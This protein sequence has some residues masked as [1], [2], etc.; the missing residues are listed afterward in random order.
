MKEQEL[1][2]RLYVS[3]K[4]PNQLRDFSAE[5]LG[6]LVLVVLEYIK[7]V[8]KAIEDGK[9][10]GEPA[11]HL[12]PDV[13]YIS[14]DTTEKELAEL[15]IM[16]NEKYTKDIEKLLK[17]VESKVESKLKTLRNGKDAEI[18][19]KQL[20]EIAEMAFGMIELP[21]FTTFI[22]QE[23]EAVRNALE[24][25]QG[26]EK[27]DMN[28]IRGLTEELDELQKNLE[29]S[30]KST[31]NSGKAV[32]K[33][34]IAFLTDV[35][36]NGIVEDDILRYNGDK[37][38]PYALSNK[39]DLINGKIP[40]SQLPSIA[41]TETFVVTSQAEMLA[42]DAQDGD[43]AVRTDTNETYV[44]QGDDP[45]VLGNWVELLTSQTLATISQFSDTTA[46]SLYT[47]TEDVPVEFRRAN[48]STLAYFDETNK[49]F[50]V[51]TI[52]EKLLHISS[53]TDPTFRISNG[54]GASPNI[55][56]ELYR[57]S[58]AYGFIQYQPAGGTNDGVIYEDARFDA[59]AKHIW[60]G[61]GAEYGRLTSTGLVIPGNLSVGTSTTTRKAAFK[62]ALGSVNQGIALL[63]G[64]STER[65]TFSIDTVST[66]DLL[67]AASGGM[68]WHTGSSIGDIT[69]LPTNLTM[70]LTNAG[71]LG[72]GRT[73]TTYR[74]ES[75]G[76]VAVTSGVINDG[77]LLNRGD[78]TYHGLRQ[79]GSS[80]L[81]LYAAGT[82]NIELNTGG[83]ISLKAGSVER[84]QIESTGEVGINVLPGRRLH[85]YEDTNDE[86]LRLETTQN[87]VYQ[88]FLNTGN[89]SNITTI[90]AINR[91]FVIRDG[92]TQLFGIN[93]A[94]RNAVFSPSTSASISLGNISGSY[95][96]VIVDNTATGPIGY[97]AYQAIVDTTN[98]GLFAT[99]FTG[100]TAKLFGTARGGY[101]AV[102]N[103]GGSGLMLGTIGDT[104]VILG[105][106]NAEVARLSTNTLQITGSAITVND[107][108]TNSQLDFYTNDASAIANRVVAN[109]R[110]V[111]DGNYAGLT[112]P[113]SLVFATQTANGA[114]G[115]AASDKLWLTSAGNLGVQVPEPTAVVH[116]KAGTSTVAPL[117]FNTGTA[118]TTPE[119]GA[120]EFSSKALWFTPATERRSVDLS[121]GVITSSTTVSNTVT[122]T[123]LYTEPIAA[124]ELHEGQVVKVRTLGRYSTANASDTATIRLKIGGTT[125]LSTV[126]SA[127]SVT[128]APIDIEFIFTVRSEGSSGT[129]ISFGRVELDNENKSSAS[130]ST[131]TIDTTVAEDVTVTIEWDNALAGNSISV[132]QGFTQFIN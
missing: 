93:G 43:V 78:G 41:I 64:A 60:R 32:G 50:G 48:G 7:S 70:N 85:V 63:D 12:I 62:A 44:L 123:T 128:N 40:S 38:V 103:K 47:M 130:T 61:N 10:K 25:L 115:E 88:E 98:I 18:T 59:S 124:N 79:S 126:T 112:A 131:T 117:K 52:P 58:S 15:G 16:Y 56:I 5:E 37:Y 3:K 107:G 53:A 108:D 42:L 68:R 94:T 26:E 75:A 129:V 22:T 120:M 132:D 95:R 90:G 80:T 74:V 100:E 71:L 39:A 49:R 21:D 19:K 51:G 69:T 8:Q 105:V 36:A 57:N 11:P 6:D 121:D 96:G 97:S 102:I 31:V 110:A 24:L 28:A 99:Y 89:G 54:G 119:A 87:D 104:P 33:S 67:I 34:S 116:I 125:I 2:K 82:N 84:V 113:T 45:S 65:A 55:K 73:P 9:I 46:K 83:N 106:N 114:T 66:N 81:Q 29:K 4:K 111:A 101:S 1:L 122:E 20:T 118:L 17:G 72:I 92:S 14:K 91:E 127:K 23:P 109:I 13:D 27:L 77:F 30:F 86:V 35:D 76:T